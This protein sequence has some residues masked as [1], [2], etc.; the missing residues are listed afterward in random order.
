VR[1]VIVPARTTGEHIG[2]VPAL[3]VR[4][5]A[6]A[7]LTGHV[8]IRKVTLEG[9]DLR[10]VR[11]ENGTVD[12]GLGSGPT[13][14]GDDVTLAQIAGAM[15]GRRDVGSTS[16]QL[17]GIGVEEG[18]ILL[19]DL[20][21]SRTWRMPRVDLSLKPDGDGVTGD[22]RGAVALDGGDVPVA[23]TMRYTPHPDEVALA[24]EVRDLVPARLPGAAPAA[25]RVALPLSGAIDLRFDATLQLQRLHAE[26]AGGE[27]TVDV[28][29]AP[30]AVSRLAGTL[31]VDVAAK[32]AQLDD[33][34]AE[35]AGVTIGARG[36]VSDGAVEVEA[37]A[38]HVAVSALPR[39]WPTD[40]AEEARKWVVSNIT[41]GM[42]RD[43]QVRCTGTMPSGDPGAFSASTLTGSASFDGLTVRFVDTM[44]PATAV[45]GV[46][47]I[48]L[49]KLGFR[50]AR[51]TVAGVEIVRATV[52]VPLGGAK[53]G[54]IPISATVRGPL[55]ATLA[56]LDQPP[57]ELAKTIGIPPA[58]AKG[59]VNGTVTLGVPLGG[60]ITTR[61]LAV[62]VTADVR[63][64]A[65][66]RML[67]GL[68]VSAANL[69]IARDDTNLTVRGPL[70]L[71]SVPATIAWREDQTGRAPVRRTIDAQGRIDDAGWASVGIDT[72]G[73]VQG[74]VALTVDYVEPRTGT[75]TVS[76]D[77]DLGAA[78]V[79]LILLD[80][81]KAAGMPGRVTASLGLKNG[82]AVNIS[83]IKLW[84]GDSHIDGRATRSDDG[85][86]WLTADMTANVAPTGPGETAHEFTLTLRP[87]G[88]R[89][90]FS[91]T[92]DD[93]GAFFRGIGSYGDA[94]GGQLSATGTIDFAA[95]GP[96]FDGSVEV[97]KFTLTKE[98]IVTRVAQ[99]TSLSGIAS[100]LRGGG[101]YFERM[102]CD[103][104]QRGTVITV[105][106]GV[107]D[108]PSL[109]FTMSGTADRATKT[110]DM[111]GTLVPAYYG[112]NTVAG[113]IPVLGRLL[114][115]VDKQ[116]IQV[117]D[118][119]ARGSMG[120]PSVT[121]NV[122]SLAPGVLRDLVRRI[123]R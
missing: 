106:N 27:G 57:I 66:P 79:D 9:P 103:L 75:S 56:V 120:D 6:R 117:F 93:A 110:L 88:I 59:T 21:T 71:A 22:L 39:W 17:Q 115:G 70:R 95:A 37:K 10:L 31:D 5:G 30:L 43:V 48:G 32:S 72:Y 92:C 63:D 68:D 16:V 15:F 107:A 60:P 94:E 29:G 46:M 12:L 114:T 123:T 73:L 109:A 76:L 87:D 104:S 65:A 45:A 80:L 44:S 91:F 1:D 24:I 98:P 96:P 122:S 90:R 111:R 121:A 58:D 25:A 52:D 35:I 47:S 53:P 8:V 99:L 100:S 81:R 7:L 34:V 112:L 89:N 23:V 67:R 69:A 105:K 78:A 102:A 74:P 11:Q 42:V 18:H 2:A 38:T 77:G 50:V 113:K 49:D 20:S 51:G 19:E 41:A 62:R 3:I 118:F 61:A 119:T 55:G 14:V 101:L 83:G 116:G 26:L 97:N 13:P 40:A 28:T 85:K 54:R 64:G 36:K 84:A 4:L 108:G 33:V 86:R 82:V